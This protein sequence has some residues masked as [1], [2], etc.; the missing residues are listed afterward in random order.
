MQNIIDKFSKN[1][2]QNE[3]YNINMEIEHFGVEVSM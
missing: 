2:T 1:K 3:K